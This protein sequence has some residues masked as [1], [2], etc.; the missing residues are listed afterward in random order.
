ETRWSEKVGEKA[1]EPIRLALAHGGMG[2]PL[3]VPCPL[4]RLEREAA[5]RDGRT[6]TAE[7]ENDAWLIAKPD[8]T[9]RN[10][11]GL[12]RCTRRPQEHSAAARAIA[13]QIDRDGDDFDIAVTNL[14]TLH[15]RLMDNHGRQRLFPNG[16]S[17]PRIVVLDE[18]HIYEGQTGAH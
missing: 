13:Y 3:K 8:P 1:F 2:Q 12:F 17:S 18:I 16:A 4:C 5:K 15:R 11:Q 10:H 6:W 7:E 14:D 9:N